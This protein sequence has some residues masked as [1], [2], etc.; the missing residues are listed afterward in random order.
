MTDHPQPVIRRLLAP[1]PSPMTGPGTNGYIVGE[2]TVAVIDPGPDDDRHLAAWLDALRDEEVSHIL[3]THAHLDHSGLARRLSGAAGAPVCGFGRWDSGRSATM[4]RLA[5]L[6][7]FTGGEG[8][9]RSFDPDVRLSD[10]QTLAGPGWRIGVLHT[11]GHFAGHLAFVVGDVALTGDHVLGWT[12]TIISPPDGD[13]RQ[14]LASCDR[15]SALGARTFLPGH[16]APIHSPRS[17]LDWL[18]NY[19]RKRERQIL[20]LLAEGAATIDDAVGRLYAEAPLAL[21]AAAVRNVLAH[22]VALVEEGRV[23][24]SPALGVEA[25]YNLA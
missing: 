9:D 18:V 11:P 13:L 6:P 10:G 24:A 21:R 14:F 23:T 20:E 22:L 15:L 16:G 12:S 5:G 25:R 7:G 17:R 3:V 1:N 4:E 19:R 8:V 2:G